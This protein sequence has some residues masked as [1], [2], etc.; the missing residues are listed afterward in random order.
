M[1]IETVA[2]ALRVTA[3]ASCYKDLYQTDV[4]GNWTDVDGNVASTRMLFWF[5]VCMFLC[6]TLP[7]QGLHG[8]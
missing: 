4:D 8:R 2:V 5:S 6:S 7:S 3:V 1:H